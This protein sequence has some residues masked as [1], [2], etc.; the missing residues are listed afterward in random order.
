MACELAT[1]TLGWEREVPKSFSSVVSREHGGEARELDQSH[2]KNS[3]FTSAAAVCLSYDQTTILVWFGESQNCVR[4]NRRV[5]EHR[6]FGLVLFI[7]FLIKDIIDV[8]SFNRP[9][10]A[11]KWRTNLLYP[12]IPLGFWDIT[13]VQQQQESFLFISRLPPQYTPIWS[14]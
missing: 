11:L 12:T 10:L 8:A 9:T 6:I 13:Q 14:T 5:L 7:Y 4:M 2:Y 3:T 1:V